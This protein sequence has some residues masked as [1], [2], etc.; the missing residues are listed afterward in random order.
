[1]G[2]LYRRTPLWDDT[3]LNLDTQRVRMYTTSPRYWVSRSLYAFENT[4]IVENFLPSCSNTLIE[5]E[6][7]GG[8]GEKE[9]NLTAI[10]NGYIIISDNQ[11]INTRTLTFGFGCFPFPFG[12]KVCAHIVIPSLEDRRRRT[13]NGKGETLLPLGPPRFNALIIIFIREPRCIMLSAPSG[14]ARRK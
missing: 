12:I 6:R 5:G 7:R 3:R 2:T 14:R 13:K 1:M 4:I 8:G 10:L 9:R 11:L